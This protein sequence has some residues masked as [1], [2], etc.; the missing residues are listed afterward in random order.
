[1]I[2]AHKENFFFNQ[3]AASW[4]NNSLSILAIHEAPINGQI[5]VFSRQLALPHQDPA[6]RFIAATAVQYGFPLAT[7]DSHLVK[8]DWLLTIG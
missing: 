3:D 8:A 1:M 7:I 4:I 2:L 5:A 6:D